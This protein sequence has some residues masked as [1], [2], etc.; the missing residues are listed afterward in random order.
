M[1]KFPCVLAEKKFYVWLGCTEV[2]LFGKTPVMNLAN[3][4]EAKGAKE[5]YLIIDKYHGELKQFLRMF[6]VIDA[7]KVSSTQV[8]PL[9][10]E[11][12]KDLEVSFY[13]MDL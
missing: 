10:H 1:A 12:I 11:G 4:A 6:K 8:K 2:S 3:L 5:L 7:T 9:I 13:K